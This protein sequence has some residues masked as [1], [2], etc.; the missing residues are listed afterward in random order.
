M[1]KLLLRVIEA[2]ELTSVSRSTAYDLVARGEWAVVHIGAGGGAGTGVRVVA[3]S[4]VEWIDRR[5]T[6]GVAPEPPHSVG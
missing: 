1:E 6:G 3:S 5:R 4:L 2:A